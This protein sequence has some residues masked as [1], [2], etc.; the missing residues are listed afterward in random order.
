ME[1]RLMIEVYIRKWNTGFSVRTSS[2]A[3][4]H[5]LKDFNHKL[6]AQKMERGRDGIRFVPGDKFF[7][8][9]YKKNE[10]IYILPVYEKLMAFY[11]ENSKYLGV[12]V[13]FIDEDSLSDYSGDD[14]VFDRNTFQ[15]HETHED[16]VW[17]NDAQTKGESDTGHDIFEVQMGKGK[18]IGVM[19][20]MKVLGKRA[21]MITKPAYIAKWKKDFKDG[22][23]PRA[24]EMVVIESFEALEDL[25]LIA[26][27]KRMN[28][29]GKGD[30]PI[31]IILVGSFVIDNYIKRYMEG[32]RFDFSPFELLKAL[33]VGLLAYDEVHQLFRMNYHSFIALNPKKII[34]LSATLVPDRDF[35]KARYKERFPEDFRFRLE[36]D[37]YI[38]VVNIYYNWG[39]KKSLRRINFMKMYNHA[40]VEKIIMRNPR[41]L[42]YYFLMLQRLMER[43]YF[44]GYG[45][46]HKCLVLFAMVEMCTKFAAHLKEAKPGFTVARYTADDDYN[47]AL[48][49]DIIV[50]TRGKSGTAVDYKGLTMALITTAVDDSQANLQMM[51]RTRK[52]VL[53]DWGIRPKVVYPV[54]RH[55]N[56]HVKYYRNR[57]DTFAG[58]V[59]SA[60]TMNG[61]FTI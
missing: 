10:Y 33:G 40:E 18:S 34:D 41:Q 11:R 45:K 50:S 21:M 26:K 39:D 38:D 14:V 44:D 36:Y 48:A 4:I 60:I 54:C 24:G 15:M 28:G 42:K 27:A 55:L 29:H 20:I 22:L 17:Q 58:K 59:N 30:K 43:W 61:S 1:S 16:F 2:A 35:N 31:K 7:L 19:K 6:T 12:P 32:D 9:D 51:G 47:K 25:M 3:F 57:M 56:K 23:N 52:G 8:Y 53:R 13:K 46:G 49:A 5:L 37:K